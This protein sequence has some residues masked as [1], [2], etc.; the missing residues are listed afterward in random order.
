MALPRRKRLK[1][2]EKV[3]LSLPSLQVEYVVSNIAISDGLRS[4]IY[5][6]RVWDDVVKIRC[7][8]DELAEL[9]TGI[10]STT[11]SEPRQNLEA[12]IACVEQR[13]FMPLRLIR[14]A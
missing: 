7:S 6:S 14:K 9:S 3:L 10:S 1:A 8:L 2:G 13:Y 4:T 12:A 11:D 5:K